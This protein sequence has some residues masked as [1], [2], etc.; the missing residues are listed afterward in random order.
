MSNYLNELDIHIYQSNPL[1]VIKVKATIKIVALVLI[2]SII[3]VI[4]NN[5][6]GKPIS[7]MKESHNLGFQ[8][9]KKLVSDIVEALKENEIDHTIDSIALSHESPTIKIKMLEQKYVNE[10]G[11]EIEQIVNEV[12]KGK[13]LE[14]EVKVYAKENDKET[15]S[16]K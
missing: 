9:K 13:E 11:T 5:F 14:Y 1:G 6:Y 8:Q 2:C 15:N 3:G 4:F 10:F 7:F 16:V 12:L